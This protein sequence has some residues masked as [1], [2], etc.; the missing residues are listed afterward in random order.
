MASR[1]VTPTK[2]FTSRVCNVTPALL[3]PTPRTMQRSQSPYRQQHQ[4]SSASPSSSS[5]WQF[6][7]IKLKLAL[8][9]LSIAIVALFVSMSDP[10]LRRITAPQDGFEPPASPPHKERLFRL[11]HPTK[12]N[13]N[14]VQTPR[15]VV[16]QQ[17]LQEL[18]AQLE[19]EER[20][21]RQIIDRYTQRHG[22]IDPYHL[23][24]SGRRA[25]L[26]AKESRRVDRTLDAELQRSSGRYEPP[27]RWDQRSFPDLSV[28]GFTRAGTSHLYKLLETH[29]DTLSSPYK[30]HCAASVALSV[31]SGANDA[32]DMSWQ[33]KLYHWHDYYYRLRTGGISVK[34]SDRSEIRRRLEDVDE[35]EDESEEDE[36][37]RKDG[38][39]NDST[40][41][42]SADAITI[43][44]TK[45]RKK[46]TVNGCLN[47]TEFIY[48]AR[49]VETTKNAK[50]FFIFRDPADWMWA[51]FNSFYDTDLEH[52][53]YENGNVRLQATEN[54]RS[55]EL[56]HEF[57]LSDGRLKPGQFIL[58]DLKKAS[59]DG[60]RKVLAE[61]GN[62]NVIF[63]KN[64]DMMPDHV[65]SSGFLEKL[66][67][68]S[69]L[70]LDG[71]DQEVVSSRTNCNAGQ[72]L[73]TTCSE[74][75]GKSRGVDSAYPVAQHRPM[76]EATRNLIYI[77]W[78]EEC[79]VWAEEFGIV[80]EAC[81]SAFAQE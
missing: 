79:Q 47:V 61:M 15:R 75:H 74:K 59:V 53:T 81:L 54:Y 29:R 72:G 11:H 23:Y 49:Y 67:S 52:P 66:A 50:A 24:D 35:D 6:A 37:R 13:R 60:P 10:P 14:N 62:K 39:E 8:I 48:R 25:R 2:L 36:D 58:H 55:P 3:I 65:E 57:V 26:E 76:L 33:Q 64:E 27:R 73:R 32:Q 4:S 16:S 45:S 31:G 1:T 9:F 69:G 20:L 5:S 18:E 71:F 34:R 78:N 70:A 68:V 19:A 38:D 43:S 40:Y 21:T 7:Y 12:K 80:Y 77:M 42:D 51:A 41:D 30:E 44:S 46:M 63:L 17:R 28:V 56:F 22:T